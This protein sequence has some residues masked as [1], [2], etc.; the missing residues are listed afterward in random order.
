MRTKE[1]ISNYLQM[2]Y[3][4]Y[5]A[6]L[7]SIAYVRV[8]NQKHPVLL[9]ISIIILSIYFIFQLGHSVG[10]FIYYIKH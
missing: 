10:E 9:K 6:L 7:K 3:E 2:Y 1:S 5:P 4:K 8:L